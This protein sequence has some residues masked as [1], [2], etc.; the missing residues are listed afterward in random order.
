MEARKTQLLLS[1]LW[2]YVVAW[3]FSALIHTVDSSI[4]G[5]SGLATTSNLVSVSVVAAG[6]FLPPILICQ[7]AYFRHGRRGLAMAVLSGGVLVGAIVALAGSTATSIKGLAVS[8]T[9][10]ALLAM[11]VLVL[12]LAPQLIVRMIRHRSEHHRS[13]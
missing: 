6:L 8:F 10:A 13:T 4:G 9:G 5:V 7:F 11:A 12:G 2:A 1:V 3:L